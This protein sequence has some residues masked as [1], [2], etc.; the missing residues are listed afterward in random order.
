MVLFC[1]PAFL[2]VFIESRL[3]CKAFGFNGSLKLIVPA[4]QS[5]TNAVAVRKA[6]H[7][8][9]GP[10]CLTSSVSTDALRTYTQSACVRRQLFH[11]AD[12]YG[13]LYY[14]RM[15]FIGIMYII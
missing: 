1:S 13:S 6:M 12:Y 5:G 9:L 7:H 4:Q 3:S 8:H 2:R 15:P 11:D 10:W 14:H